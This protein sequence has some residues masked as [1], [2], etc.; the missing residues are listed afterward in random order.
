MN[1]MALTRA[2]AI[3]LAALPCPGLWAQNAENSITKTGHTTDDVYAAGRRVTVS[4]DVAGD[5][6][7]AGGRVLIERRV[8]GDV[9]AAGGV[10]EIRATVSDDVRAAGG[11]VSVS[12]H[13]SGDAIVAG[14]VVSLEPGTS[15]DGRAWLTGGQVEVAGRIATEL[16]A[17]CGSIVVAG[18]V[19]GDVELLS[20][21]L[22]I[23]PSARVTGN[24]VYRGRRE[25]KISRG[26]RID[27][28]L[29]YQ[30]LAVSTRGPAPW[31]SAGIVVL[32]SLML[33]GIVL[34]LCFPSFAVRAARTVETH[35]WQSLGLGLAV[36]VAGPIVAILL[37][38]TIIGIPLAIILIALYVVF[39][40]AGYLTG[41]LYVS[42]V[43]LRW[44]LDSPRPS[45]GVRVVSIIAGVLALGIVGLIPLIGGLVA[46]L[47]LLVGLGALK[48]QTVHAYVE[49]R[50]QRE[51]SPTTRRKKAR[52]Q[53]RR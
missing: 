17:A 12:G 10:V 44:A 38:V 5:V 35:P 23:L 18:R 2:I 11:V 21:A 45:T 6:I 47:V 42:D 31:R 34:F 13:I 3:C 20:D 27:G 43:G 15:V 16:K 19:D 30:P 46:L 22:E 28:E 51:L 1:P 29:S 41:V 24:L 14:G 48:L 52:K 39:L 25:A 36:L 33:T 49:H 26:A 7:A 4:A 50:S 9:M 32:A 37:M 40:I 53:R 8:S